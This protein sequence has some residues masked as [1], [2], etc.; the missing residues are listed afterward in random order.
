MT[1]PFE[2]QR[3][4]R[5]RVGQYDFYGMLEDDLILHDPAHFEKLQWFVETFGERCV[6]QPHRCEVSKTGA[7][8]KFLIDPKLGERP[9][10]FVHEGQLPTRTPRSDGPPPPRAWADKD[11]VAARRLLLAREAIT[12]TSEELKVPAENLLTPDFVR[13]LLWTP[14]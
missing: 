3:I 12:A 14:P 11:P 10:R 6:L 5:E 4:L 7:P 8:A 9:A 13:R 1:L 2:A